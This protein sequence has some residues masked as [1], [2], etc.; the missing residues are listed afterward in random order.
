MRKAPFLAIALAGLVLAGTADAAYVFSSTD[1]PKRIPP[2]GST[3]TTYSTITIGA[4]DISGVI[5]DVNLTL[6]I[7]HTYV[8]DLE[9]HVQSAALDW[10]LLVNN[11]D[12]SGDNFRVTT[13]DDE[14]ALS[15]T[16]GSPPY[17]G[18]FRPQGLLSDFDG[19]SAVGTWTLRIQDQAC[20][21]CGCL[22]AW[23]LTIQTDGQ[24]EIPEPGSLILLALGSGALALVRRLRS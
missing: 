11:V 4:G 1:V 15:I 2:S 6:D 10:V 14:A 9:I 18:T 20:L 17:N 22:H 23:S 21:D 13:F 7:T 24:G 19:E 16:A 8:H 12:G 5:T 3:G